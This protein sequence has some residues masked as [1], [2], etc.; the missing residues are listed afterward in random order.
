MYVIIEKE[1]NKCSVFKEKSTLSMK[2]DCSTDTIRRKDK[3]ISWEWGKYIVYNPIFIQEKSKR[4]TN[5][6]K[7]LYY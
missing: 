3:L 4:G 7:M 6:L 1:T 5:N 2:I